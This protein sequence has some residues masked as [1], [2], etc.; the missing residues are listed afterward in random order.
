MNKDEQIYWLAGITILV[1]IMLPY[2]GL[3]P[4][5]AITDSDIIMQ[6]LATLNQNESIENFLSVTSSGNTISFIYMNNSINYLNGKIV[7]L[8][9][10]SSSLLDNIPV[11]TEGTHTITKYQFLVLNETNQIKIQKGSKTFYHSIEIVEVEKPVVQYVNKTVYVNQTVNQTITVIEEVPAKLTFYERYGLA[12][13][14]FIIM[15]LVIIY[16]IYKRTRR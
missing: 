15:G 3:V 1:I 13:I 12:G 14:I 11:I 9:D 10:N 5:F 2:L 7:Y 16:L 8:F 4:K 6:D